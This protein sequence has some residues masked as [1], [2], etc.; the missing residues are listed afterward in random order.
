LTTLSGRCPKE[1]TRNPLDTGDLC[2]LGGILCYAGHLEEA[3]AIQNRLLELDPAYLS[4]HARAA[5]TLLLMGKNTNALAE[6]D[7]ETDEENRLSKLALV[8][9]AMSRRS[10]ADEA[11]DEFE[12][13]FVNVAA[14]SIG[15]FFLRIDPLLR[16]LHSDPRYK[17][18]LRKI[19]LPD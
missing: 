3:L 6:A 17:V 8:Y 10:D 1:L 13:K 16:N 9:W 14:Y 5:M 15:M 7:I 4:A 19:N 11:L 12:S 18:V 2:F